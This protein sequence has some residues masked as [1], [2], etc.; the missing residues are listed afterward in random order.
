MSEKVWEQK[1]SMQ[2]EKT[3]SYLKALLRVTLETS[4]RNT[5]EKVTMLS[6]VGM[7]PSEIAEVLGTTSNTVSVTLSK[8]RKKQKESSQDAQESTTPA[9]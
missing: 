9:V 6:S 4:S 1:L 5:T 2:L 3:N 7:A 8:L